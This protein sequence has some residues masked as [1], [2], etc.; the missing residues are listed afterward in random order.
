MFHSEE[1]IAVQSSFLYF[2]EGGEKS[3]VVFEE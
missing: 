2:T 1:N 3:C